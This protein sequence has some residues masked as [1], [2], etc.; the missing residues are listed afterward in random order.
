MT[1][2]T[3]PAGAQAIA[4]AMTIL[5]AFDDS[6]PQWGL[7][8][9]ART[10]GLNKT[11]TYRLLSALEREGLIAQNPVTEVYRLG[12]ESIAL[13]ARALRSNDLRATS[14]VHLESLAERTGETATLEVLAG[15]EMLILDEVQSR[16]LIGT[17]PSVGTRWPA[18]ATSTGKVLLADLPVNERRALLGAR[19]AKLTSRTITSH[20]A[21]NAELTRVRDRGFAVANE[22]LDTGYVAVSAPVRGHDSHIVAALSVGGPSVRM[23]QARVAGIATLTRAAATKI[24]RQLG[25]KA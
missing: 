15:K 19:L 21:L 8:E 6:H 20:R 11:T 5:R 25:Y 7:S 4:R 18:H 10:T 3:P 1:T 12:P 16:A 22:E 2:A 9:L 17:S 13:G 14:R 24:S 23:T